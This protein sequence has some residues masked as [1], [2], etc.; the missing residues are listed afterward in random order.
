MHIHFALLHPPHDVLAGLPFE[1]YH[2]FECIFKVTASTA[3]LY[4]NE[5]KCDRDTCRPPSAHIYVENIS[6]K[7]SAFECMCMHLCLSVYVCV[8]FYGTLAAP[9]RQRTKS[10][11]YSRLALECFTYYHLRLLQQTQQYFVVVCSIFWTFCISFD[12]LVRFWPNEIHQKRER[13][14][15]KLQ[16]VTP[17]T[18]SHR[19]INLDIVF[20][21]QGPT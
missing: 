11:N 4:E 2:Q 5:W 19:N 3:T 20:G 14:N 21:D 16:C 10:L 6:N 7:C 9:K 18:I 8:S 15:R 1:L 17:E 12:T 13:D